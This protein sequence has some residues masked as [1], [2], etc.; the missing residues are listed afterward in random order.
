M[1]RENAKRK[2]TDTTDSS[3]DLSTST[4]AARERKTDLLKK[5][6]KKVRKNQRAREEQPTSSIKSHF[7]VVEKES[8]ATTGTTDSDNAQDITNAD[9][10]KKLCEMSG[11]LDKVCTTVE[12]LKGEIFELKEDNSALRS[13]LEKCKQKLER[14]E[15]MVIEAKTQASVAERR[16][17][18]LEQYGRRNNVRV[19]GVPE[20]EGE[21][22]ADCEEKVLA[23][24]R[25]KL[26]LKSM[27]NSDIE[28]CHRIGQRQRRQQEQ[29]GSRSQ[30]LPKARPIIVRFVNRKAA[31]TVLY[32][33][34]KLK[35]TSYVITEDL[36]PANFSLLAYCWDHPEVEDS[37]SKRGNIIARMKGSKSFKRIEK[38]SDL[39]DLP[40]GASTPVNPRR[41]GRLD[42]HGDSS[43]TNNDNNVPRDRSDVEETLAKHV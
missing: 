39:P 1:N 41:R 27:A 33:R 42:R 40:L 26:G 35:S 25:G 30:V 13:E 32:H 11:Q 9:I 17:N 3:Q 23:V 20:A 37:W 2:A 43:H 38:R 6:R 36:T 19:L 8:M 21:N 29:P 18:D 28:A 34:R 14:A 15:E 24:L 10:L 4:E 5:A 22:A 12:E 31:E 7:P 16:V